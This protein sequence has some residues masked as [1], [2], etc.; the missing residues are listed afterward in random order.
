VMRL[1]VGIENE[2][3]LEKDLDRALCD[4]VSR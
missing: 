2:M 4:G 1:S 3:D